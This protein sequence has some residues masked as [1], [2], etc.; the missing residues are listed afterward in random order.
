MLWSSR[1]FALTFRE[2]YDL[3]LNKLLNVNEKWIKARLDG[4]DNLQ[5][6]PGGIIRKYFSGQSEK[7]EQRSFL[8]VLH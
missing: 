4:L 6:N 8:E 2:S 7:L 5:V 1:A 3:L